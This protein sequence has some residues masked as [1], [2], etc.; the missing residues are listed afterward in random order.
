VRYDVALRAKPDLL[1]QMLD[2]VEEEVRFAAQQRW[3]TLS[4]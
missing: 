1:Q 2:D 4:A 3:E